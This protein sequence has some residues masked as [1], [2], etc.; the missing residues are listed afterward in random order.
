M[1]LG[2]LMRKRAYIS[3]DKVALIFE[4]KEIT[5]GELNRRANRVAHGLAS[6]GVKKGDRVAILSRN[7]TQCVEALFGTLKLGGI[8]VP[9]NFRLTVEETLYQVTDC[10][11]RVFIF[12]NEFARQAGAARQ[13]W[14]SKELA[15]ITTETPLEK[16]HLGYEDFLR[17]QGESEPEVKLDLEDPFMIMYTS[18]TTGHPKG[19]VSTYKKSFFHTLALLLFIDMTSSDVNLIVLP[20]F[21]TY[22]MHAI[23][24]PGLCRGATL[25]ILRNFDARRVLETIPKYR[26]T[27]FSAI[28]MMLEEILRVPDLSS[29]DLSSLKYFG[30]S[31]Q[32]ISRGVLEEYGRRGIPVLQGF[33]IT[34]FPAIYCLPMGDSLRKMGS[35]G[36]SQLIGEFRIV[37]EQFQTVQ[38]GEVGEIIARGPQA[39]KEYWKRPEETKRVFRDGWYLTGDLARM[40]E[41]GYVF[42]VDRK[43]DMYISGGENVYPAEVERVLTSHPGIAEAAVVGV[44]DEKWGEAGK[45]FIVPTK[46]SKATE[47][48]ILEFCKGKLASYKIP[49]YLAFLPELPKTAS[50]KVKKFELR[51]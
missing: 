26:V 37:N 5:Y 3:R 27:S 20:L 41:E 33:G 19:V 46:D 24:I 32:S 17:E 14:P 43:K 25:V 4:G 34:E 38:L 45:A 23:L 42:I 8:F 21:H 36:L 22:G 12:E 15:L 28:P 44:K 11:P 51:G 29:F 48:E 40:D 50:G 9:L 30:T 31:A 6:L 1:P 49:K 18:G 39:M 47:G 16:D 2:S 10:A 13:K 7:C 35:V